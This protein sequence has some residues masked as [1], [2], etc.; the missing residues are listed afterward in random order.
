M[1]RWR[2]RYGILR[3]SKYE[4]RAMAESLLREL[5][6]GPER[7]EAS[8]EI[9]DRLHHLFTQ[10]V[11]RL[12]AGL[13]GSAR[14]FDDAW[15]ECVRAV[16]RG[17]TERVHAA[18]DRFLAAFERRMELLRRGRQ[19]AALANGGGDVSLLDAEIAGMQRLR[20]RVFVP[21]QTSDD[22]EELAAR[23]YPLPYAKLQELA[24]HF[25]PPQSWYDEESQPF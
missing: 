12:T 25:K 5:E 19:L 22:L 16:A 21:W 13:A 4:G 14:S 18:H 23:D 24:R 10:E 8:A 20:E 11:G 1:V 9:S 15:L 2:S 6:A 7:L 17:E 3:G